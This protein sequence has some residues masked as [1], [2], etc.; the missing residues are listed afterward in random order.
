M[1]IVWAETLRIERLAVKGEVP[2]RR[3]S[4]ADVVIGNHIIYYGGQVINSFY[5][6]MMT[7]DG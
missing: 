6:M 3:E 7:D 2:E 4:H 1:N 5:C